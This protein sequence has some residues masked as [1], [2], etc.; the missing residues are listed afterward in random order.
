MPKTNS[1]RRNR[2]T[3]GSS[4]AQQTLEG[5]ISVVVK[6]DKVLPRSPEQ[7]TL[8]TKDEAPKLNVAISART[9]KPTF[10]ISGSAKSKSERE[11]SA[12]SA[13]PAHENGRTLPSA[14]QLAY[15]PDGMPVEPSDNK[16]AKR[17]DDLQSDVMEPAQNSSSATVPAGDDLREIAKSVAASPTPEPDAAA[18]LMTRLRSGLGRAADYC[19]RTWQAGKQWLARQGIEHPRDIGQFLAASQEALAQVAFSLRIGLGALFVVGGVNK[20]SQLLSPA[21]SDRIVASY[22]STTGYINEFFMSF[23]FVPGTALTP[24]SFLTA[25]SAFELISG[26]MLL[27]G[28]LV[29]PV[30]LLYAFMLWTFVIALPV[31]T[32]NGVDPGV[33]TYMAPA[34]LVQI[35]D[36]ALSGFMFVLYGLGSGIRSVDYRLFGA[37]AIKPV[38]SWDVASVLLRLSVGIVLIVGGV[39]AGMPNIKTYVEPGLLLAVVGLGILWGG[40]VTR[41]AAGAV[42]VVVVVYMLSK[43]GLDKGLI[44]SLNAIKREL[45]IFAGAFVLAAR[46]CGQLWTASDVAR[47]LADGFNSARENLSRTR[48]KAAE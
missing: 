16:L 23:L 25:L 47:R 27:A 32:T 5:D 42:C 3:T 6:D 15:G 28:F 38:I 17:P 13:S 12:E 20:L 7:D 21:A 40:S 45:A 19:E 1:R 8:V 31:V 36:I 9:G 22:T 34:I 41:Y 37:G 24:W 46:E 33:K 29:R 39:F 26:V 11:P 30:A 4:Q 14:S 10:T 2:Q 35:R 43:V 44:G 18:R 48:M